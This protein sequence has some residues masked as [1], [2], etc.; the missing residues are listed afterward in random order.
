MKT[1]KK[2][3]FI[4]LYKI[5]KW[6][7]WLF[8]PKMEVVG[9]EN[10]P[11]EAAIIVGNHTQLNGPI[12]CEVYFPKNRYTWCAG[13]MMKLKEVPAYAFEDF[14]SQK[15]KYTHPYFKVMSYLIAPI[16]SFLFNRANTIA[17]YKDNRTVTTFKTTV[18]KLSEGNNV[19]IFPEK[20]E[21]FNNILYDF[22]DKFIDVARLYK[23][24][25]G[26]DLFFAPLYI[27]PKLKK[28]C[29]GKPIKFNPDTPIDEER[30]RIKN[31]L[32]TEIT[33]IATDLP[34]HTVIPYR[35]I[36]KK[37]YPKNK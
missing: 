23:K 33:K 3:K 31:Y 22:Q 36:P 8:Y 6:L 1:E 14:W 10:L 25:T 26:K 29:L 35:N 7:I 15:P 16:S 5:I 2:R 12:A 13:Q 19:V 17:V 34:V 27:T 20:D 9:K 24:R 21:K 18:A 11:D 30:Q 28:M 4:W 37:Y 32:M